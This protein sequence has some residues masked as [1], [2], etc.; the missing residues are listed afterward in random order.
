M[1]MDKNGI[2]QQERP[3]EPVVTDKN[4]VFRTFMHYTDAQAGSEITVF[5]EAR[6]ELFYNYDDRLLGTE[7]YE[8]LELAAQQ[9]TP[10]TARY[11]EIALNH[12]HQVDDVNLRH[13]MLGCNRISG[14]SYL[15]FGYTYTRK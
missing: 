10:K 8:G 13:V 2:V 9:A 11:Y 14:N 4:A 12:F 1:L 7:W 5:G 15:I 3:R 6:P